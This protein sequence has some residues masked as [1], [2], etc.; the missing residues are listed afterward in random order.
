ME[1]CKDFS[2]SLFCRRLVHLNDE[3]MEFPKSCHQRNFRDAMF[4]FLTRFSTFQVLL[5]I[6]FFGALWEPIFSLLLLT[7]ES[8]CQ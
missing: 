2:F 6:T 7:R 4:S 1:W 8:K 5:T 3:V